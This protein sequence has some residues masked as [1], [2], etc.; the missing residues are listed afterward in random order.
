MFKSTPFWNKKDL[1]RDR[2]RCTA[3]AVSSSHVQVGGGGVQ[4]CPVP[5]PVGGP[6]VQYQCPWGA[7]PFPG[8]GGQPVQSQF[9]GVPC[10]V[11]GP[12]TP[13]CT[14]KLKTLPS[15]TIRV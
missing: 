1:H 13:L 9:Q 11:S 15:L 4:H 7:C 8:L 12:G 2:Q 10:P 3:H 6:P 5:G 14:E